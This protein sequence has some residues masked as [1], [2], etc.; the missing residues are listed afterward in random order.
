M[1]WDVYYVLADLRE[2]QYSPSMLLLAVL[3][4]GERMGEFLSPLTAV[5]SL[6]NTCWFLTMY[7]AQRLSYTGSMD[8]WIELVCLVTKSCLTLCNLTD[9]SL[10][11][12]SV[13]GDFPGRNMGVGCRF[14]LQGIFPTQGS[15]TSLLCWQADSLP[16]RQ[17]R[18]PWRYKTRLLLSSS[19]EPH[20]GDKV[21]V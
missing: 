10:L 1:G 18:S 15:N 6:I 8:M 4:Y 7:K 13:H 21:Y 2:D 19:L 5:W 3:I 17:L 9:Y 11:G 14:L 16:L 12:S 20:S